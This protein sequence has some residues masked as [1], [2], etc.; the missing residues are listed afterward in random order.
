MEI[1]ETE[2]E[3]IVNKLNRYAQVFEEHVR[4]PV[5][6]AD[7]EKMLNHAGAK[8]GR[9]LIDLA[10][11]LVELAPEGQEYHTLSDVQGLA[12][13]MIMDDRDLRFEAVARRRAI[14]LAVLIMRRIDNCVINT[15]WVS[16]P[17][18]GVAGK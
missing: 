18:E 2:R 1:K 3:R 11:A 7:L 14:E 16:E 8:V 5:G 17:L 6:D 4:E 13:E 10:V 15:G 9:A 12:R